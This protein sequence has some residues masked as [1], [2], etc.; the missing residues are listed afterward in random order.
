M[1]FENLQGIYAGIGNRS[2]ACV[3]VLLGENIESSSASS[4]HTRNWVNFE[5][6]VAAGVFYILQMYNGF[7]TRPG[8]RRINITAVIA[9]M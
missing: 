7:S 1:E 2:T 9:S 6:G 8:P 5:V 3:I 4:V